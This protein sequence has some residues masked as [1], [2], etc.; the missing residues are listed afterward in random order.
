MTTSIS[1][2][3]PED[4][5]HGVYTLYLMSDCFIGLD[6]QYDITFTA[7]Q[8]EPGAEVDDDDYDYDE[9]EGYDDDDDGEVDAD[10]EEERES[11]V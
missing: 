6:Q 2:F 8:A 5:G 11:R 3:T 1:F 7:V 4:A 10:E 9:E